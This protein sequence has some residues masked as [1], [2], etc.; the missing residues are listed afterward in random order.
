MT[1]EEKLQNFRT[2]TMEMVRKKRNDEIDG[3]RESMD[4]A[5]EEYKEQQ[6]KQTQLL[7]KA[8]KDSLHREMNKLISIEHI[9]IRHE[10][11]KRYEELKDKLFT[12]VQTM[13]AEYMTTPAYEKLLAKQIRKD[14]RFARG[15][16]IIIYI[17]P[18][19]HEHLTG[20]QMMTGAALTVSEY[21]F[22]GGTRAVLPDRNV[23]IDDSF[24]TRLKEIM[25]TFSFR[26]GD[27][28]GK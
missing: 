25:E 22:G 19:D 28:N 8:Q 13:L 2:M 10:Y 27:S 20:L 26:G 17:D 1:N 21:S 16:Q 23:L 3:Y 18:A 6:E 5:F 9:R 12:E 7:L 4:R 24:E 11:T 14:M 15:E